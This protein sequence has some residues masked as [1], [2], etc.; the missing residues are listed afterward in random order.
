MKMKVSGLENI[1]LI[2]EITGLRES[3]GY[4]VMSARLTTPVGWDARA[5]LTHK[6][7]M[8]LVKLLLRPANLRY[9]I[10]GF[11]QPRRSK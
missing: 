1:E 9:V 10:F 7:L 8:T 6:D 3:D 5:S 11:G 4:L 2:G